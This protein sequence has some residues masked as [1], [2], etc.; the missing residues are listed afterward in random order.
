MMSFGNFHAV[1]KILSIFSMEG[2]GSLFFD[3]W[4]LIFRTRENL[5]S[6]II[7]LHFNVK[8]CSMNFGLNL[9]LLTK[10]MTKKY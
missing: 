7:C 9:S 8:F 3:I 6:K 2:N 1:V 10:Q 5:C 4:L